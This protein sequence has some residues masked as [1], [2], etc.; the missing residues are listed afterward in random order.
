MNGG[1]YPRPMARTLSQEVAD[2]VAW[3]DHAATADLLRLLVRGEHA[4]VQARL[5]QV[6]P[7]LDPAVA[8]APEFLE[9]LLDELELRVAG[10]DDP[11][12]LETR[13]IPDYTRFALDPPTEDKPRRR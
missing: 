13:E 8:G 12:D 2:V 5:R 7:D 10:S 6:A 3:L 9:R 4:G 1:C 11:E